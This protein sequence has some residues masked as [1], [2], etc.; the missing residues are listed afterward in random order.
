MNRP[1]IQMCFS[2]PE[3]EA[4]DFGLAHCI[5][6]F[7]EAVNFVDYEFAAC[8]LPV[9]DIMYMMDTYSYKDLLRKYP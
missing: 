2:S 8:H 9:L 7:L 1:Q 3:I 4:E 6:P 5:F